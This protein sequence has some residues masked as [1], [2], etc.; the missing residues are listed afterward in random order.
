MK[1]VMFALCLMV[2]G[3][4]AASA[5]DT[6]STR[7]RTDQQYPRD[8][9]NQDQGRERIQST[10]LPDQVKRTLEGQEYLG[11]LVSGAFK[12]KASA[13]LSSMES[14]STGANRQGNNDVIGDQGQ[15]IY[16]VE[17]KNGAETKTVRFD[18][19]GQKIEGIDE[20]GLHYQHDPSNQN[21]QQGER[22]Q[23]NPD[24]Q[25]DQSNQPDKSSTQHD[26]S[27]QSGQSSSHDQS[28]SGRP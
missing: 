10:D 13:D 7:Y 1:R 26:Q 14:D 16:I 23:T 8:M 28:S 22:D 15:Q 17:L 3:I 27:S 25:S 21:G 9:M 5:Q 11:W 4:A 24:G 18:E 19:N 6:T 20:E 12:A 2:G